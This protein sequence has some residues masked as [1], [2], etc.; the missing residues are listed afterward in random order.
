MYNNVKFDREMQIV[1]DCICTCD[2]GH[3]TDT[4]MFKATTRENRRVTKR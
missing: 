2:Y 4:E 1:F 3:E